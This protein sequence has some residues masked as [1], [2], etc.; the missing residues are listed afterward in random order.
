MQYIIEHNAKFPIWQMSMLA[1]I[2]EKCK[3]RDTEISRIVVSGLARKGANGLAGYA[4]Q[5]GEVY[6]D[7]MVF[8]RKRRLKLLLIHEITHL[9]V[10]PEKKM[11]GIEFALVFGVML[12]R[13]YGQE[14]LREL[15]LYD[16]QDEGERAGSALNFVWTYAGRL[17]S[18]DLPAEAIATVADDLAT[19]WRTNGRPAVYWLRTRMKKIMRFGHARRMSN[20]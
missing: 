9:V 6:I 12:Y 15:S 4:T 14:G 19:I 10:S 1:D 3:I 8:L 13:T 18:Q 17:A 16:V 5:F 2:Y 7:H 20:C 11:H